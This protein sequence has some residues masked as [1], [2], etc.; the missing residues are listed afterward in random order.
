MLKISKMDNTMAVIGCSPP[1][2]VFLKI[3]FKKAVHFFFT[4]IAQRG[5][6]IKYYHQTAIPLMRCAIL[7]ILFK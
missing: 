1:V 7:P 3:D 5:G 4:D 6:F 2:S